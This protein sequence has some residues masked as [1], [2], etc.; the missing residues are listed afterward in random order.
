MIF[1]EWSEGFKN[2]SESDNLED[3][4]NTMTTYQDWLLDHDQHEIVTFLRGGYP[5]MPRLMLDWP[6]EQICRICNVDYRATFAKRAKLEFRG[7]YV[8]RMNCHFDAW[9]SSMLRVIRTQTLIEQVVIYDTP[10]R[11]TMQEEREF[12]VPGYDYFFNRT[13]QMVLL[14]RKRKS[15]LDEI[16][17]EELK[18]RT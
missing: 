11:I 13:T 7:G 8:L 4:N 18:C 5:C 9:N 1:A 12:K 6:M 2:A 17:E 15:V 10:S 3:L 14:N 16:I